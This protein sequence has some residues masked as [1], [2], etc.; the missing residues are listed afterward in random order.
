M[1]AYVGKHYETVDFIATMQ[2]LIF[3]LIASFF[4]ERLADAF[5]QQKLWC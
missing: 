3:F 5:T 4:K 2:P 1:S